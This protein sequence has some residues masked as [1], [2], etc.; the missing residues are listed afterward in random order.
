ME[1]EAI[2]Q[3]A[4][5]FILTCC[6]CYVFSSAHITVGIVS[7]YICVLIINAPRAKRINVRGI[8]QPVLRNSVYSYCVQS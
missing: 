1:T 5:P 3:S 8:S 2:L 7:R 4:Y 6:I